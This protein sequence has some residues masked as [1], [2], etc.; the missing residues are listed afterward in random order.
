MPPSIFYPIAGQAVFEGKFGEN[1]SDPLCGSSSYNILDS[2][3]VGSDCM[4][5][6]SGLAENTTT[7]GT[8]ER[9]PT[10]GCECDSS[11]NVQR[12]IDVQT[13]GTCRGK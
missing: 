9:L 6:V 12:A 10:E 13:C 4:F 3:A 11:D 2:T 8:L 1:K 7:I 5:I